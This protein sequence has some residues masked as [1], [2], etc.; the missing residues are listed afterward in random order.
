MFPLRKIYKR[1]SS[2]E[3]GH[4]WAIVTNVFVVI[5]TFYLG[6]TVQSKVANKSAESSRK[7][8]HYQIVDK[9]YP[10]YSN[11]YESHEKIIGYLFRWLSSHSTF[12]ESNTKMVQFISDHED[13]FIKMGQHV[14]DV[15]GKCKFYYGVENF[16]KS[17]Q[18]NGQILLGI[19][20]IKLNNEKTD[21]TKDELFEYLTN[22][23]TSSEFLL[24]ASPNTNIGSLS[25]TIYDLIQESYNEKNAEIIKRIILPSALNNILLLG[26]EM[27]FAQKDKNERESP[28]VTLAI[29]IVVCVILSNFFAVW[30]APRNDNTQNESKEYERLRTSI[31]NKNAIIEKLNFEIFNK[32]F[33]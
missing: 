19:Q 5:I 3:R 32:Y 10:D 14:A 18:D 9:I 17:S 22:Y 26:E 2:T 11:I 7:L 25:N 16:N 30:I 15:V 21:I 1:L 20:A 31:D 29:V 28:W 24:K 27:N 33:T 12:E 6:L 23:M 13:E 4:Y 8:S